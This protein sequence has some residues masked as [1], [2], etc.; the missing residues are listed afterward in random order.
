MDTTLRLRIEKALIRGVW[1]DGISLPQSSSVETAKKVVEGQFRDVL[2]SSEARKLFQIHSN[3]FD[4]RFDEIYDSFT[5]PKGDPTERELLHLTFAVACFHSFIQANWTGP[6]LD[7]KP[8]EVITG[9]GA[10]I[11][12]SNDF[13]NH[14]AVTELSCGG[15]P[16]YHL[17][18][19]PIFLRLAQILLS[20]PYKYLET[21][22]W[23]RLRFALVHQQ[24]LDEPVADSSLAPLESLE[25][26]FSSE[27]DLLGQLYLEHGRL[28]HIYSQDKSAAEYFVKAARAT[29]LEY[30]LTGALGKRTKFQQTELSQLVLLA[31]SRLSD[32]VNRPSIMSSLDQTAGFPSATESSGLPKTLLLNDDTLLEQTE[33]TS[34]HPAS[35]TSRL[36]HIN[37]Q[38]QPPLHPID[39]CIFLALCLNVKNTSPSHGLTGEQMTPYVARVISDPCN[40]SIHTMALLLRSRLESSRTRT[41]ERSTLQ[42]Q[43]LIDQM[44]TS[45]SSLS[46]RLR[47]FHSIPL[48]SKWEIEKELALRFLSLGVV[49]SALEIFER[50]EMWEEVVKCWI[51]MEHPEKGIVIIHDLLEGRKSEADVVV[52][53][54]K[55][56]SEFRQRIQDTSREAKLW[57]FLGDLEPGNA[58]EY[59]ERAWSI[60]NQSSGRSMRA[61]GGYFFARGNYTE[62]TTC[63]KRAVAINPLLARTWFILGCACMRME[64]WEGARNAFSRCVALDED[65]GESWSNLASMYLRLGAETKPGSEGNITKRDNEAL[66]YGGESAQS[67]PFANKMQAFRAL[68]QGLRYSYENWRMWYNYMIVA[69]DV[70]E[71]N[72]A[73]RALGRVV[74]VTSEKVGAQSVDEDVLD[75]LVEAVTRIPADEGDSVNSDTPANP[76]EGYWLSKS[77]NNLFERILLPRVSSPRVFRSYGRLLTWQSKWEQAIKAYLDAYRNGVAGTMEKGETDVKRWRE[78]VQEVEE[79]VD[80][81]RNFGPRAEDYKW[82]LQARSIVRTF[83]GRTKDFEDETDWQRLE[84]LLEELRKE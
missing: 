68:K 76:N 73:C 15:E 24:V 43:A 81:L 20:L 5:S 40:W 1:D 9:D 67:I 41:V 14:K 80:I 37:F 34:S 21:I 60:S 54:G 64:D 57:C 55:A 70:G 52:A 66:V 74:E 59:Y 7:L 16:A 77:V 56:S 78:G 58:I 62:A 42:L 33:F 36:T 23:W 4:R 65:D 35:A 11:V 12:V 84:G 45:D 79:I 25:S 10:E 38:N 44:P 30:E 39:Q 47:Y 26:V 19:V 13:V 75:R 28:Y 82:R 2:T 48:P 69:M 50:L 8:L 63:L 32:D 29:G 27:P 72:E 61:L 22:Q 49:K 17:A 3:D 53:R 83:A 46:E 18:S 51:S 71:L 6:D 31:E